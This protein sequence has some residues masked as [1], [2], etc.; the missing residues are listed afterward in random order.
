[1]DIRE[2]HRLVVLPFSEQMQKEEDDD[3]YDG[4]VSES[5]EEYDKYY[6]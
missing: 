3:D 2:K 4:E 5:E 1:M 6:A